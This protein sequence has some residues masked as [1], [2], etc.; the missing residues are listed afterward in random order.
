MEQK[1]QVI[2]GLKNAENVDTLSEKKGPFLRQMKV[3]SVW[4]SVS[5]FAGEFSSYICLDI[6]YSL[7]ATTQGLATQGTTE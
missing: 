3:D 2:L 7:M 6:T 5:L 4:T 1:P